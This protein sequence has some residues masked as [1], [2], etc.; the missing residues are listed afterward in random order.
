MKNRVFA[1]ALVV[2]M[3]TST[4]AIAAPRGDASGT[5]IYQPG[6]LFNCLIPYPGPRGFRE[7]PC[8]LNQGM[9][10]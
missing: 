2:A 1:A 5:G 3:V 10:Y 7:G 8:W 6:Q 9:A 4:A